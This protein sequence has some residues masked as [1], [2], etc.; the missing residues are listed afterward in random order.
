M[1]DKDGIE[2][3]KLPSRSDKLCI[4][5]RSFGDTYISEGEHDIETSSPTEV[6]GVKYEISV[7]K[8][9]SRDSRGLQ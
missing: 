1:L 7:I 3:R 4:F 2:R 6:I 8:M 9:R 5:R